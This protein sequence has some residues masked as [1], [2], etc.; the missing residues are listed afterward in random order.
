MTGGYLPVDSHYP[1]GDPRRNNPVWVDDIDRFAKPGESPGAYLARIGQATAA[2]GGYSAYSDKGVKP[3]DPNTG[4]Y[5]EGSLASA[6]AA[7]AKYDANVAKRQPG[8]DAM[9]AYLESKRNVSTKPT[10]ADEQQ[11]AEEA[12]S[13]FQQDRQYEIAQARRAWEEYYKQQGISG[14]R[15][16]SM[17]EGP[18]YPP[19]YIENQVITPSEPNTDQPGVPGVPPNQYY[20]GQNGYLGG[21][22]PDWGQYLTQTPTGAGVSGTRGET[23]Y[24]KGPGGIGP[25]T[26]YPKGPGGIAPWYR[27]PATTTTGGVSTPPQSPAIQLAAQR[28]GQQEQQLNSNLVRY[29]QR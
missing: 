17:V 25:A 26:I 18:V 23:S 7:R 9:A 14:R 27:N 8:V 1:V 4:Y 13:Q 20:G 10:T 3:I 12:N 22:A 16:P 5:Y 6:L 24:P 2:A 28:F 15:I 11:K 29:T 21:Q 19:G